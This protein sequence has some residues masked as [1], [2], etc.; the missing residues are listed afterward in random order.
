M[1]Q[2]APGNHRADGIDGG[3]EFDESESDDSEESSSDAGDASAI[4]SVAGPAAA[5]PPAPATEGS[6]CSKLSMAVWIGI[7]VFTLVVL[8]MVVFF[9]ARYF[10]FFS[11]G[12]DPD[13]AAKRREQLR[14]GRQ[15]RAQDFVEDFPGGYEFMR[16]E[17]A[18]PATK[19]T[20][21][22]QSPGGTLDTFVTSGCIERSDSDSDSETR[23]KKKTKPSRRTNRD[24]QSSDESGDSSASSSSASECSTSLTKIRGAFTATEQENIRRMLVEG[25]HFAEDAD[26]PG[27]GYFKQGDIV[28]IV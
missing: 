2:L 16:E 5:P 22:V 28:Q 20:V 17:S 11:G 4:P 27:V 7:A 24:T 3:E 25:K 6:V 19:N 18:A 23:R 13:A 9:V 8:A 15:R 14:L 1:E 26:A 10:S 21:F 12:A